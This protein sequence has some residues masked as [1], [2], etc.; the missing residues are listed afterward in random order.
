MKR[1]TALFLAAGLAA[2]LLVV[3]TAASAKA[4]FT[5][6]TGTESATGMP[7]ILSFRQSGPITHYSHEA[8][9]FD[10][11]SD[12]RT[13]GT[14]IVAMNFK[15]T[16]LGLP[17]MSGHIWG[18]FHTDVASVHGV[19]AWDGTWTGKMVDG[20]PIFKVVGHGSGDLQGLKLKA[21]YEGDSPTTIA[22][23][24]R[25]LDPHGS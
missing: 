23:R 12:W 19:G 17:A 21:S 1:F 4:E 10:E 8:Y 25:I 2:S 13:T 24:G 22:I 15:G 5:E 16:D 11:T 6:Y 7:T 9:Y 14:T 20:V 3:P 18:T